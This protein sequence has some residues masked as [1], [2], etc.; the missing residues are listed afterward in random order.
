MKNIHQFPTLLTGTAKEASLIVSS[1]PDITEQLTR[2]VCRFLIGLGYAPMTEFVLTS[3]RRA[4][5]IAVDR[6]GH[7]I[8]V[9]VKSCREDFEADQKWSDYVGFCDAFYFAVD[10]KFPVE[11]LPEDRGLILADSYGAVFVRAATQL[12]L[13]A[14][15][16][17]TLTLRMTRQALFRLRKRD[18]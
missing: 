17:K 3:R 9:E 7:I 16:R 10:Q 2:G 12:K 4:D 18:L 8:I 1:R 6:K 15:R 13:A 5:I 14:A 11:V